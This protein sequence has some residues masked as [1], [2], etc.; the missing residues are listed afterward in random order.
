MLHLFCGPRCVIWDARWRQ[1][2]LPLPVLLAL[3]LLFFLL[4]GIQSRVQLS[5]GDAAALQT[6]VLPPLHPG[7]LRARP[8]KLDDPAAL[9][10]DHVIVVLVFVVMLVVGSTISKANFARKAQL[11]SIALR[12]DRRLS[13]PRSDLLFHQA[14]KIFAG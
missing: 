12:C 2:S 3:F 4:A 6:C 1:L 7:W 9:G 10:T 13:D 5:G 14:I 11:P 8:R